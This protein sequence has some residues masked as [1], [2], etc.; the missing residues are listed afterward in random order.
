MTALVGCFRTGSCHRDVDT[1]AESNRA[2]EA[3]VTARC[4][5]QL[6]PHGITVN[7]MH[8]GVTRTEHV[9]SWFAEMAREEGLTVD[10]VIKR[11]AADPAAQWT[12]ACR[13]PGS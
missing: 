3:A 5:D 9:E 1:L 8:P 2:D 4:T 7:I 11:E 10:T 12:A 6:G 13:E